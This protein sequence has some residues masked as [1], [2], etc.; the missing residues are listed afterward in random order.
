M[1]DIKS[2]SEAAEHC[3]PAINADSGIAES[4]ELYFEHVH[5]QDV[6]YLL[7]TQLERRQHMKG[8]QML[9]FLIRHRGEEYHCCRLHIML[10]PPSLEHWQPYLEQLDASRMES[11]D[12]QTGS[13]LALVSG[14]KQQ[15]MAHKHLDEYALATILCTRAWDNPAT[16]NQTIRD[17]RQRINMLNEYLGAPGNH[18]VPNHATHGPLPASREDAQQELRQLWLYLSRS[19]TS[20]GKIK[21]LNP[22]I[23]KVYQALRQALNRFLAACQDEKLLQYVHQHLRSGIYFGWK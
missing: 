4:A 7:N 14:Q 11:N 12:G 22:E 18:P 19:L 13:S 20:S 21:N 5:S 23:D 10:W 1:T 9:R 16:D 3:D 8:A 17:V 2:I 6:A 15:K